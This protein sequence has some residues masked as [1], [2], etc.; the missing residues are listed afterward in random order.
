M[1]WWRGLSLEAKIGLGTLICAILTV[2]LA[3]MVVP[4][5]RYITGLEKRPEE[6][7]TPVPPPSQN[8]PEDKPT[9]PTAPENTVPAPHLKYVPL[10]NAAPLKTPDTLVTSIT[11]EGTEPA[12]VSINGEKIPVMTQADL[13]KV[14]AHKVNPVFSYAT[15]PST[16]KVYV[17]VGIRKDG[18]VENVE[19]LSGNKV[20]GQMAKAAIRQWKFKPFVKDGEQVAV[21]TV[22]ELAPEAMVEYANE[23]SHKNEEKP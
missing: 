20:E 12:T 22:I 5:F 21:Q 6:R 17:I 8:R 1:N 3:A 9:Q 7:A 18:T 13:E 10:P 11:K 2:I 14:L 4:E 23:P 15:N 16:D 19:A